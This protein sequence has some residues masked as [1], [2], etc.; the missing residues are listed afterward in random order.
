MK[1]K[2]ET[3]NCDINNYYLIEESADSKIILRIELERIVS[4]QSKKKAKDEIT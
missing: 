1:I 2:V 3:K 4:V